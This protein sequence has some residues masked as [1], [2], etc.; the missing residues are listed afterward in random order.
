MR[1]RR[2]VDRIG[3]G[4]L[5]GG[6]GEIADLARVDHRQRQMG[7]R[8]RARHD[9]LVAAGGFHHDQPGRQILQPLHELHQAFAVARD[10]E[11]L[12]ARP[13]MHGEPVLCHIDPNKMLHVPSLRMRARLA[14]PATVR[15]EGTSG[16]GTV[17][18]SGLIHPRRL[19]API[20]DRTTDFTPAPR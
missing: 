14:A 12:A 8:H 18:R 7:S 4:Q 9:R 19:R 5:A 10:G 11:A 13:Q 3:L 20:R 6:A 16:W 1:N 17:L 2:G 15:A